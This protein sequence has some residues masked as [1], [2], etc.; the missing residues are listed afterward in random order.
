MSNN[1]FQD[2]ITLPGVITHVPTDYTSGYDTSQ[3]GKTD[4]EVIIG[5]AFNGPVGVLTEVYSVEHAI[6]IFGQPYDSKKRQEVSLIPGVK[7]AWD[8]G[9]RTIYCMRVG[10]KDMYRDFNFKMDSKYKLRVKSMFPSNIG[11]ECYI[12]FSGSAGQEVL[13]FY[14]PIERATV[15]EKMRGVAT[16]NKT[17]IKNSIDLFSQNLTRHDRLVDL[18]NLFNTN[19]FNNVLLMSIVDEEGNDVTNAPETY[20]LSIGALYK[21]AY[22]I[23]RENT[24]ENVPAVTKTKF[25]YVNNEDQKPFSKFNGKFY[26]ELVKN[27]D[28]SV[29]YPIFGSKKEL[30]EDLQKASVLMVSDWDFLEVAEATDR[31]FTPDTIDYEETSLTPFEIYERLGSGFAVT[32]HAIRRTKK[33]ANGNVIELTPRIKESAADD[34]NHVVPVTEGIYSTLESAPIRYRILTCANADDSIKGKLPRAA[35]FR[36]AVANDVLALNGDFA[37]TAVVAEDDLRAPRKYSLSF[38]RLP[39]DLEALDMSTVDTENIRKVVAVR[40][41]NL[42]ASDYAIGTL[43]INDGKVERVGTDKIMQLAPAT[44]AGMQFVVID[45]DGKASFMEA[46]AQGNVVESAPKSQ[47]QYALADAMDTVFVFERSTGKNLGDL[48]TLGDEEFDKLTVAATNLAGVKN[49]V[50]VRSNM[51]DTMTVEELMNDLN[52]HSVFSKVFHLE[53]TDQGSLEKDDFV[54]EA[55]NAAKAFEEHE[56]VVAPAKA[57]VDENGNPVESKPEVTVTPVEVVELEDRV[58]TYDYTRYIPYRT[59]DNFLRQ[60]AQHCTYTELKTG[61]THGIMGCKT[62]SNVGLTA[63]AKKVADIAGRDFQLYAK[64]NRGH[65]MLDSE[66]LPYP[67]GKNVSLVLGQYVVTVG[68]GNYRYV[69]NGAAGYGGM[70]T[71][72]PLDQS[73]TGQPISL[74]ELSYQ[75]TNSQLGTLTQ[76]GVV[77]FNKSFTKGTVV[78]DGVTMAPA[79]SRFRRLSASRI[80]GAVEELIRAAA[81]P[82][83]GKENHQANR[84]ALNTA[85]KSEL[86]KI[87]GVL[88]EN[89]DFNMSADP[90]LARFSVIE[91]FYQIVPIYE[92]REVRNTIK[93]VDSVSTAAG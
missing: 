70:V 54:D 11:K 10:G 53:L 50:V 44:V 92:I 39:E 84:N 45:K 5:T 88:I 38:E 64:T 30:T 32:A 48:A 66:S 43:L 91:I 21:G 67:I 62:M 17:V 1:I 46:D 7:D 86:D 85:I 13:S 87:V 28:V 93:M 8:R 79:N 16:G 52:A 9:C 27:T 35:A 2:E 77:T 51:F 6:Y 59:N 55:E 74:P 81:E 89:Y 12:L 75:L 58:L 14:K 73:S 69:S 47:Y 34:D 22:F 68:R 90:N 65:N 56:S 82:Y 20:D 26:R 49:Q 19:P 18:I 15:S 72:L 40:D 23:G 3:F 57:A 25:V 71:Q 37:A 31:V 41:K 78:T 33:D 63:V 36:K 80:M 60:L 4:S 42:A 24:N 61:P 76:M 29:P 83:I